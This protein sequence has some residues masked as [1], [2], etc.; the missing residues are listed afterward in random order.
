MKVVFPIME[1]FVGI[2]LLNDRNEIT[3]K[4]RSGKLLGLR[5]CDDQIAIQE[6]DR[7]TIH[8]CVVYLEDSIDGIIGKFVDAE[9]MLEPVSLRSRSSHMLAEEVN[10]GCGVLDLDVL[11][12]R[13][14][15]PK[16]DLDCTRYSR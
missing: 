10:S 7:V 15:V 6:S 5:V 4:R 11:E 2:L 16:H 13:T 12:A 8:D 14:P 1:I 9:M 3:I